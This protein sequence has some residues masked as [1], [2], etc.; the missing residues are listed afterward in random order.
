MGSN[1]KCCQ[2]P[3]QTIWSPV[4]TFIFRNIFLQS[5][6]SKID[7]F[8]FYRCVIEKCGQKFQSKR[9][10]TQHV[11]RQHQ[12]ELHAA[13]ATNSC[14]QGGSNPDQ[15]SDQSELDLMALLSC[16]A[17]EM[18][19][20]GNGNVKPDMDHTENVKQE[21]DQTGN[22]KPEI[23]LSGSEKLEM[24]PEQLITVDASAITPIKSEPSVSKET[25]NI[26][27]KCRKRKLPPIFKISKKSKSPDIED[28][29]TINMQD[30]V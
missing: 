23:E 18:E 13:A 8:S 21:M 24:E 16:V 19:Q 12:P 29:S 22:V 26:I 2:G 9:N 14:C 4:Y 5:V 10:L 15:C 17:A 20:T 27:S 25:P 6:C 28:N 11:N 1:V 3:T 30:L 7:S